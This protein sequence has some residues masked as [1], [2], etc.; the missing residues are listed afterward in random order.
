MNK[1]VSISLV[2][3][4]YRSGSTLA[5]FYERASQ[6]LQKISNDWEMILVDDASPDETWSAA[7]ALREKD[8]RVKIVRFAKNKGQQHATLCGLS[9]A[10][11]NYVVTIDDDL[12]CFPEDLPLFI[13][14]LNAGKYVVIGKIPSGEKKHSA[15]RNLAS[16]CNKKLVSRIMGKPSSF[17]LS[18]YRAMSSAVVK[19][20]VK[21][22]G[23][24]P[25]IAAMIFNS[26]P[27][28]MMA[29]VTIR[30]AARADG[31]VSTYTLKKLIKTIS[32]L[33]VNYS[34]LPLRYV[35]V[36]GLFVSISSIFFAVF[37]M[38]R[39]LLTD[40]SV[41]GWASLATLISFLAGNILLALGIQGEYLGRLVENATSLS[42]FPV[43]E[44]HLD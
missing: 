38:L 36:W 9:Y 7:L 8:A 37:I 28:T 32:F 41:P 25:H 13:D 1:A 14:Q 18:S 16:Q 34:L 3:P 21:Y 12:Q 31:D 26:V 44:E 42:Q 4:V 6:A 17:S 22:Q 2:V 35:S 30:H 29:N 39:A 24:H 20:L 27:V 43:I 23:S 33:I 40:H 19:Q 11:K 5:A 10:R 15:W